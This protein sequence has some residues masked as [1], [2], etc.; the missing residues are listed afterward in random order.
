MTQF[1][2]RAFN[3][4]VRVMAKK[5]WR[6]GYDI[7]D[8]AGYAAAPGSIGSHYDSVEA[9]FAGISERHRV[10]V[11]MGGS[12][13]TIFGEPDFNY[14]FRAWHEWTHWT[15]RAPF[16]LDGELAVAHRQCQDLAKVFGHGI[17]FDCWQRYI[18]AEVYGQA[19]H[20]YKT[21]AFPT[22]QREFDRAY[23]DHHFYL[24]EL[25]W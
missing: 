17:Q 9:Y 5:V 23:I 16:D 20:H 10:T 13:N 21:G 8:D 4:A 18:M 14:D 3:E 1:P 2:D 12:D 22:N 11:Y 24:R 7:S 19:L 6:L 25:G 15:L